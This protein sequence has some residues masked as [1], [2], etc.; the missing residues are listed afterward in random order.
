M[1][2]LVAG[3]LTT[4]WIYARVF[5]FAD[6]S[7]PLTYALP[8]MVCL[9]TQRRWHL[10]GMAA[11]FLAGTLFQA[12]RASAAG[13][14]LPQPPFYFFITGCNILIDAGIIHL[15]LH[16]QRRQARH[17]AVIAEK[18]AELEAR[19]E[20]LARQNEAVGSQ[21][22]TLTRQNEKIEAQAEKLARKNSELLGANDRLRVRDELLQE[23][24]QLAR[25]TAPEDAALATACQHAL[26]IIGPPADSIALLDLDGPA[27]LKL[28]AQAGLEGRPPLP[29]QWPLPES[30][31]RL[32]LRDDK[33]VCVPD[34]HVQP[35]SAAPF[36]PKDAV[37]SL[38]GTPLRVEQNCVGILVVCS[39]DSGP[40]TEAQVQL[41]EWIAA[42]CGHIMECIRWRRALTA[43]TEELHAANR[44]KDDFLAMLSHELRTPLTPALAAAGLLAQDHRLPPD[45]REDLAMIRSN[46]TIQSRLIDD[47]L[48]LTRIERGKLDF[49]RQP[50]A[51]APLLRDAAAIVMPDLDAR[52]QLLSVQA[53]MPKDCHIMGDA[54]RIQQVFWNLLQNAIKFSPPQSH[55]IFAARLQPGCT[56]H[57]AI[58]VDDEGPGIPP[59]EVDRV[60]KPFVQIR[61]RG[62]GG[63][64]AGLG[65]GLAIAKVIVEQHGGRIAVSP[66]PRGRGTRFTVDLPI[67]TVA[68]PPDEASATAR[69][70]RSSRSPRDPGARI[71]LVEDHYDT[72][73]VIVR[74]LQGAGH[75]V[76]LARDAAD[77]LRQFT[78]EKFDLVVSDLGLPDESGLVLMKKL[79]ELRPDLP[80]LCMSG[81]GM[82][83]DLDACREVGFSEH[84][85]KPVEVQRL[86]DAIK[87]IVNRPARVPSN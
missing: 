47:L 52:E 15:V 2:G 65:L 11:I 81:Y 86:L 34:L 77:A 22:A 58:T 43:R 56:S 87:R 10:W 73:R 25:S 5:L 63:R 36:T 72:G 70:D 33:T 62:R 14:A 51:L 40:W 84:L 12:V 4:G 42:K 28:S 54:A 49:N 37:R 75:D 69:P 32:V 18:N 44:A 39:R 19:A 30:I 16:F 21:S 26:R 61:H 76:S 23:L 59:A 82:E 13:S 8:L 7:P 17:A 3:L 27:H 57:V 55:I 9:W 83:S 6:A 46:I 35:D 67:S 80:G 29:E 64:E 66:N 38:L 48:D 74:L 85:T 50:F 31:A 41:L 60:F 79:R 20:V 68:E 1:T 78:R 24:L 71:L 45:V 53:E